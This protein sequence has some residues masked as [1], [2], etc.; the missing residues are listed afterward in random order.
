MAG[1]S[2]LLRHVEAAGTWVFTG[3]PLN[4]TEMTLVERR[5]ADE[6]VVFRIKPLSLPR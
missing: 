3:V 1:S 4:I 2:Q 6:A 5:L